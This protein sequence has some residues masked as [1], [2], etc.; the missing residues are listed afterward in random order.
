[1][2][3][4]K[5]ILFAEDSPHDVEMTL[6]AFAEYSVLNEIV[7]VNDGAEA[8][9][10]LFRR[11]AY[12]NRTTGNPAVIVLD[13]KMPKVDGLEV[14][15]AVRADEGLR[16]TPVVMLTSS[17]EEADIIRSYQLGSNAYL[18]KP[19]DFHAFTDA[20]RQL[21]TFWTIHNEP[22]PSRT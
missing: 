4:T 7:V 12:A 16:L 11:G 13:V 8:L 1:M 20:V 9:D 5:L 19:V 15:R 6:N 10:F 21:G 14:L 17:R 2:K 22:Y 3:K 18:V